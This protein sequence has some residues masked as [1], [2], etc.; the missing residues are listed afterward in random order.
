VIEEI[1]A[2]EAQKTCPCCGEA[3]TAFGHEASTTFRP[4]SKS[5][6]HGAGSIPVA[7]ATG[8]WFAHPCRVCHRS[9]RVWP[10]RA[11]WRI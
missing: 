5:T 4:G 3:L 6:R 1:D 8:P 10:R 2:P 11:F 9:P 7:T